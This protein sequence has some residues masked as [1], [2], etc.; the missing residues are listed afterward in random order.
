M[1]KG[2]VAQ[3][4]AE[5]SRSILD[6][7]E[8]DSK[9]GADVTGDAQDIAE[10]AESVEGKQQSTE[11]EI[12]GLSKKLAAEGEDNNRISAVE[13]RVGAL[14]ETEK[15]FD[16]AERRIADLLVS[17][18]CVVKALRE[19]EEP[20]VRTPDALLDGRPAEFKSLREGAGS[21]TVKNAL[22]SAKGQA[23]DAIVDARGSGLEEETARLGLDRFLRINPERMR[24]IRIIGDGYDIQWPGEWYE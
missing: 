22:N 11:A 7:D 4:R 8:A 19:S 1:E 15:S 14:D 20:G 18:G 16:S 3:P 13:R 21:N 24:T 6:A 5:V 23:E 2:Q 9:V 17:E 10:G 12:G